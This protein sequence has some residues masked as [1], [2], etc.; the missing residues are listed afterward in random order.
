MWT[1]CLVSLPLPRGR[2]ADA[3]A[4]CGCGRPCWPGMLLSV[5]PLTRL[6]TGGISTLL[7]PCGRAS[8]S[9]HARPSAV[10]RGGVPPSCHACPSAP[11]PNLQRNGPEG[12][13]SADTTACNRAFCD[14]FC[15]GGSR[16][17]RAGPASAQVRGLRWQRAPPWRPPPSPPALPVWSWGPSWVLRPPRPPS[18]P[19]PCHTCFLVAASLDQCECWPPI[20]CL[21]LTSVMILFQLGCMCAVRVC[22][23]AALHAIDL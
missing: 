20:S 4:A 1:S 6:A 14:R 12:W 23:R 11:A 5:G 22:R 2:G 13:P 3:A 18:P 17:S 19:P 10:T 8:A 7:G 21:V 9:C 15:T 16:I